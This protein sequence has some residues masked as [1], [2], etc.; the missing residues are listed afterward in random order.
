MVHALEEIWRVLVA[1]GALIDLRPLTD[2]W[3]VEVVAVR[4]TEEA[5]R[6]T[7]LP[8][9]LA[10]DAAANGA[11]SGGE[12]SG[13][14][15]REREEFFPFHYSWDSPNDMHEYV[16]QEWAD[17]LGIEDAVWRRI[18]S[19][20]ALADADA[21]VRVRLKMLITRWVKVK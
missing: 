12:R 9:G 6:V 7:A 10:D 1:G 5:G 2:R 13:L 14:F 15:K 4:R 3:P 11:M 21:R 16:E 17:F 19:L 8:Q 20:W 18:R